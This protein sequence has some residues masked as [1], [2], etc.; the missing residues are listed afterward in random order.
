V[1]GEVVTAIVHHAILVTTWSEER[2][3]AALEKAQALECSVIGPTESAVNGFFTFCICPDGSKSFW[4]DDI[5]GD[6]RRAEFISWLRS[7]V[8]SDQSLKYEWVE[9]CYSSELKYSCVTES[10]W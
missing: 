2:L 8:H 1:W 6:R 3:K 10:P 5:A 9:V 4:P 7:E